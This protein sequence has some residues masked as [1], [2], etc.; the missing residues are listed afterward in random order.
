MSLTPGA[1]RRGQSL[2]YR[3]CMRSGLFAV[4]E[5]AR[6]SLQR[7]MQSSYRPAEIP[8]GY[9]SECWRWAGE[10][11][12]DRALV[13]HCPALAGRLTSLGRAILLSC[14]GNASMSMA[15]SAAGPGHG[16]DDEEHESR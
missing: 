16:G 11:A 14:A 15:S 9:R 7:G 8:G 3:E 10:S 6:S 12:E 4:C 5:N 2:S 1:C 13:D